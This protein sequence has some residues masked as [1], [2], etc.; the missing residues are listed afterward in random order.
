M[1]SN[2]PTT[3]DSFI[4]PTGG[5]ALNQASAVHSTQHANLN[6][7][8]EKLEAK[9]GIDD[10]AVLTS[11][12]YLLRRSPWIDSQ[13]EGVSPGNS[14]A[15][16]TSIIDALIDALAS[17]PGGIIW[18]P[19]GEIHI[20]TKV[21]LDVNGVWLMGQGVGESTHGTSLVLDSA[22]TDVV[23]MQANG[24]GVVFLLMNGGT[25]V[26]R[27]V[28]NMQGASDKAIFSR[29]VADKAGVPIL[30][31]AGERGT[32]LG[33]RYVNNNATGIGL[34]EVS[35]SDWKYAL[36]Q[37]I[38]A[39]LPWLK[40][41]GVNTKYDSVHFTGQ[42]GTTEIL[43]QTGGG[44][45]AIGC[46]LDGGNGPRIRIVTASGNF[47]RMFFHGCQ[48]F[49]NVP[50]DNTHPI[51]IIDGSGGSGAHLGLYGCEASGSAGTNRWTAIVTKVDADD[52][53]I[54][55]GGI[56]RDTLAVY[57]GSNPP[58]HFSGYALPQATGA[59]VAGMGMSM[60]MSKA[61]RTYTN[62]G[63]GPT[64]SNGA[65]RVL[66]AGTHWAQ[67]RILA[68]ISVAGN[69]STLRVQYSTDGSTF[70]AFTGTLPLGGGTGLKASAWA[71]IPSGARQDPIVLRMV[72]EGGDGAEDPAAH[73]VQVEVR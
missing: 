30:R 56:Y 72:A 40:A 41:G 26:T 29:G 10:S 9:V 19:R 52:L 7:A 36:I 12:D 8:V 11:M 47:A 46:E 23:D 16:N 64:E 39:D 2:F 25:V 49:A 73:P 69:T 18:L 28:L 63:A 68:H 1:P 5:G 34:H 3:L 6:D 66:L 35:G 59:P 43:S 21:L 62:Q 4:D 50:T 13:A 37:D 42:S 53:V 24:C 22:D 55:D 57:T 58:D 44:G 38:A 15:T 14:A 70:A 32:V 54:I 71:N 17:N 51:A 45:N 65:D 27:S 67:C 48:L 31:T 33:G 20:S 60:P 61:I